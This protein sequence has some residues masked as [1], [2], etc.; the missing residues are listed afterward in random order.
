[1]YVFYSKAIARKTDAV[2]EKLLC[3]FYMLKRKTTYKNPS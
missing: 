3:R 1:M 2:S